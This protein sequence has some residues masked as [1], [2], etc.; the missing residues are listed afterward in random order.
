M[1]KNQTKNVGRLID[2]LQQLDKAG[3]DLG[4]SSLRM[5][6]YGVGLI[7]DVADVEPELGYRSEPVEREW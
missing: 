4:L 5:Q 3:L 7:R 6:T 2:H 1:D